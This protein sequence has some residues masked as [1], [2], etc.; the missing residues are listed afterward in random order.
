VIVSRSRRD[1]PVHVDDDPVFRGTVGGHLDASA[2]RRRY[3]AAVT[4]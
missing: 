4:H 3:V 1:P 2:L